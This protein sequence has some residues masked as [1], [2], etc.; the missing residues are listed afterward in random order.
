[1]KKTVVLAYS[2]GARSSAAVSWLTDH[3]DAD[4]VTVTLDLG[5]SG[6]LAEIRARAMNEAPCARTCSTSA[7]SFAREIVLPSLKAGALSDARYPMATA[8][9]RPLIA[10][11]FAEIAAIEKATHRVAWRERA[12]SPPAGAADRHAQSRS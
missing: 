4:V 11:S 1:M 12:R 7:R 2:G 5:Q 6:E 10:Q 9:S 3:H 8:L